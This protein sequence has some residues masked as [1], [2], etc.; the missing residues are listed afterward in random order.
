MNMFWF[1]N[2]QKNRRLNRGQVLDVKLRSTKVRAVR[3]RM[4]AVSLLLVFSAILGAYIVWRAGAWALDR[5]LY[6]NPAFAVQ[7]VDIETDG[8]ISIDQLRRWV[9]VKPGVNLLALDLAR[10]KRNLELAPVVQS[11]AIERVVPHTL[12]IRVTERVPVAQV[13]VP[14][15]KAEGGVELAVYHLGVDGMV[16][17][18]LDPR[19][20]AVPVNQPTESLPALSGVQPGDLQPGR[21]LDMPQVKAALILLE[22]F[23]QSPMSGLVDVKKVDVSLPEIL[24]LTTAQGSE[25]TFGLQDLGQQ[26]RRWREIFDLGNRMNRAIASLDLAV[27]NNIPARWLEASAVPPA[28][29]KAAKTIRSRK[30]NV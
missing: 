2:K 28:A 24:V 12:R 14:R 17:T 7:T 20:R 29:P 15:M 4:A 10:V 18:P 1:R 21:R 6:E 25:I 19:Q 5:L 9:A 26:L 22:A 11:V 8:E 27:T 30:K 13:T 23:E 16:M 3:T